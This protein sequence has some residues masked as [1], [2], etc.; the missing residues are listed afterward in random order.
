MIQDAR[1]E[2]GLSGSKEESTSED[3]SIILCCA[4]THRD[5]TPGDHNSAHPYRRRKVLQGKGRERLEDH[6]RV[7]KD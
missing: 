4:L 6:V 1:V 5:D 7:V 3:A 2:T